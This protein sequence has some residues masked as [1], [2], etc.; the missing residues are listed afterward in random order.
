[1]KVGVKD[2]RDSDEIGKG[3][4]WGGIDKAGDLMVAS[5]GLNG[6]DVWMKDDSECWMVDKKWMSEN[7]RKI[8]CLRREVEKATHPGYTIDGD[9]RMK[10]EMESKYIPQ[11]DGMSMVMVVRLQAKQRSRLTKKIASKKALISGESRWVDVAIERVIGVY[12]N[13]FLLAYNVSNGRV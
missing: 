4:E 9:Q 11:L 13:S 3:W 8:M 12:L 6:R 7:S 5:I 1:M 10:K 2:D